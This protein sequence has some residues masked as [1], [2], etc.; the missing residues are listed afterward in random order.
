[1]ST[2]RQIAARPLIRWWL[3]VVALCVFAIV[4]V[5][6]ATRLTESGLSITEW[7]PVTGAVPPLTE[8][9]WREVFEKYRQIPQYQR[10]NRG[11]TLDEFKTIYWWEWTHRLLGRLI[12]I[13]FLAPFL[14]FL[15]T[16]RIERR[17]VPWLAGAFVLGGLQGAL[18]WYMV[19]S[20]LVDRVSVSQYRLAAHLVLASAIFAYLIWIAEGLRERTAEAA[21][22]TRLRASA[23]VI[24]VLVFLQIVLGALVAGLDAGLAYRT[25]PLMDGRF[26][27]EGLLMQSP[28]WANFF[29]NITTVQFD[30]RMLAYVL[31]LLTLFHA[32]DAARTVEDERASAR[33][34]CLA[35]LMLGQ[36]GLG[37]ATLML[38]VPI[39]LALVHQAGAMI[40]LALATVHLHALR[41][42]DPGA[43]PD[44]RLEGIR[45]G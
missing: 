29:E 19:A 14:W 25:W 39:W 6:G 21:A 37:I 33:A 32:A 13:V 20:G 36:A 1:M 7:Q 42:P 38:G 41:R 27:P 24:L 5:G 30:H 15:A 34:L 12:G 44:V 9:D 28:L 4:I 3:W 18:G 40:V 8:A 43:A 17:L 26:V 22:S 16:R 23:L 35:A 10:V 11:M 2:P 45:A 31:V